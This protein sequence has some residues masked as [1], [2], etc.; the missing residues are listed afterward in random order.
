MRPL[1]LLVLPL[2][3]ACE[4]FDCCNS[5]GRNYYLLDSAGETVAWLGNVLEGGNECEMAD[6]PREY[7]D[8]AYTL[9]VEVITASS[10]PGSAPEVHTRGVLEGIQAAC[11][12]DSE[13]QPLE[14]LG[15]ASVGDEL[16]VV[17]DV[18]ALELCTQ[19]ACAG[20]GW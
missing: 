17:A 1:L 18:S 6:L 8:A 5:C 2:L 14:A 15:S 20:S 11:A 12:D 9:R 7:R 19:K 10:G 16:C 13:P 4:D 3:G